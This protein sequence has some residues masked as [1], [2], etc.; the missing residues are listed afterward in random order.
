MT[1]LSFITLYSICVCG[2]K[3]R[4]QEG[5][6]LDMSRGRAGFL[7]SSGA[8]GGAVCCSPCMKQSSCSMGQEWMDAHVRDTKRTA[9]LSI[10]T[11]S[12]RSN[13]LTFFCVCA[14]NIKLCIFPLQV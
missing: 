13:P 4:D 2:S 10:L 11:L 8:S 7:G 12:N 3:K 14:M 9:R 1:M 6:F 5:G